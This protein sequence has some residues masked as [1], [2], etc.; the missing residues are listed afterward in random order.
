[1]K[2]GLLKRV[3]T[4]YAGLLGKEWTA[5][6]TDMA[7]REGPWLQILSFNPSRFDD[8]YL[9]RVSLDFLWMPGSVTGGLLLQELKR[10][11]AQRW[12]AVKGSHSAAEVLAEMKEQFRPRLDRPLERSEVERAIAESVDVWGHA[13]S[14]CLVAL[15]RGDRRIAERWLRDFERQVADKPFEWVRQRHEEL[16]S[17]LRLTQEEWILRRQE[18]ESA[19]LA[20]LRWS[21]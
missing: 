9:P 21:E 7:R 4:E 15:D 13:Y 11:G 2:S 10:R 1:M 14:L 3:A 5:I 17:S 16:L 6:K 8:S 19:K 18:I 12:V 20:S